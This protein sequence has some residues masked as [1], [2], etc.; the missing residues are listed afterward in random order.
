LV[1]AVGEYELGADWT[2]E[3]VAART[4]GAA[5]EAIIEKPIDL[6]TLRDCVA[7]LLNA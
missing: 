3:A 1:T 6:R 2:P 5:P 7:G 4:G